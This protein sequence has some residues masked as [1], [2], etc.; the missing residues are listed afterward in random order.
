M[1]CPEPARA[2]GG[3]AGGGQLRAVWLIAL[4]LAMPVAAGAE[5]ATL[6]DLRAE[7]SALATDLQSLRGE[8]VASGPEGMRAAGGV[9]ALDRMNAMEGDIARLTGQIES[10]QNRV[11]KVVADGANRLGDLEFRLCEMDEACDITALM[12][13]PELGTSA[14]ALNLAPAEPPPETPSETPAAPA[15]PATLQEGEQAALDQARA[16]LDRGEYRR[17][18]DLFADF[19]AAYPN[20]PLTGEAR[21]YMGEALEGAGARRAAA[22]AWLTAFSSAP[23]GPM[24]G[25]S[26]LALGQVLGDLEQPGEACVVLG[27]A[28]SRFGAGIADEAARAMTRLDCGAGGAA[29]PPAVE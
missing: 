29:T 2:H 20:G 21:F 26:L 24:A 8:L 12:Q 10:L 22:E 9:T 1:L 4:A 3:V 23:D 6:A 16:A 14:G 11:E 25:R 19:A 18:A 27:E 15:A 5:P 28:A 13:V 17:A 7:L